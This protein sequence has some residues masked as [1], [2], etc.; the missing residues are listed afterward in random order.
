MNPLPDPGPVPHQAVIGMWTILGPQRS[1]REISPLPCVPQLSLFS[2]KEPQV[3]QSGNWNKEEK[4]EAIKIPL[5]KA[6]NKF[7]TYYTKSSS[8]SYLIPCHSWCLLLGFLIFFLEEKQNWVVWYWPD[9]KRKK[10]SY[11]KPILVWS[12]ANPPTAN[13]AVVALLMRW[14]DLDPHGPAGASW[15]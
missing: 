10:N 3:T 2:C 5:Q 7:R 14:D 4:Q 9:M 1:G 11:R 15:R 6:L 8:N 13:S 12:A